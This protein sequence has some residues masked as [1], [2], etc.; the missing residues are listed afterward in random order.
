MFTNPQRSHTVL[1]AF[2]AILLLVAPAFAAGPHAAEGPRAQAASS[3]LEDGPRP[4]ICFAPGTSP[5]YAHEVT[6]RFAAIPNSLQSNGGGANFT[7][8]TRWS[9]TATNG[10]GLI[11]GDPTTITWSYLP[12]G[13]NIGGFAGEPPAPSNLV[14]WLNGIYGSFAVWHPLFVQVFDRWGELTGIDYVYEPNDDGALFPNAAGVLGVRGDVRIGAH[15]IDGNSGILAYNF[16]PNFGDMVIDSADAFYNNTAN[17]SLALRNVLAHEHGHGM[18]L[19]HVCPINQTK[20]MEPFFS[21]SFDGPQFDDILGAQ[22]HYGDFFEHNDTSATATNLG[23][24]GPGTGGFEDE[25]SVDDNSDQN[26]YSFTV[27]PTNQEASV[28]IMPPAVGPYLSGP[29]LSS[30]ACSA[31]TL[32]DPQ[33]VHDLGVEI[34]DTDGVTVLASANANP[35]GGT[36]TL[37]NVPLPS[38]AGPYYVRVF[39]DT[40]NNI[41]PYE[42]TLDID[43]GGCTQISGLTSGRFNLPPAGGSIVGLSANLQFPLGTTLY[44]LVGTLTETSATTGTVVGTLS[45]GVAPDPDYDVVGTYTITTPATG[46]QP[47]Y[48]TW[49]AGIYTVG[50]NNQVGKIGGRWKDFPP[51]NNIGKH[52]SEW[53]I[54]D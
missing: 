1:L 54:C 7:L 10:G 53:K 2:L 50:T 43:Q 46:T 39:G 16:F 18:G 25:L 15:L 48:G 23:F 21:A 3:A 13:T 14:A 9:V 42:L 33:T 20:L 24:F 17:N 51:T 49:S 34:I 22:R 38:G 5:R 11:Q 40:T 27:N 6:E 19:S 31:G 12:D 29:Q 4:A 28:T 8:N 26:Y 32:F 37:S 41:Q 47:A 52:S 35:A 30:G 44:T 45:D 36:E